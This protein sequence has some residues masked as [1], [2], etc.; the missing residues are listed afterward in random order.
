MDDILS[1]PG[2]CSHQVC[3]SRVAFLPI[4]TPSP[5]PTPNFRVSVWV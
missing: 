2:L 4:P 5:Y 1:L 3:P